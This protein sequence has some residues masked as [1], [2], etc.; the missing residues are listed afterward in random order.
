MGPQAVAAGPWTERRRRAAELRDR[1]PFAGEVLA[2]YDALLEA[3]ARV[4]EAARAE[5]DPAQVAAY[6]AARALPLVREVTRSRGPEKLARAVADG[7]PAAGG[8]DAVRRWLEGG[9]L[10]PVERY[11]ARASAGPVLEALGEAAGAACAGPRDARHCPRCGGPPQLSV[12]AASGEDLV[13]PRRYLECARCAWR[14]PY[15]RMTCAGCGEMDTGRLPIFAEEGAMLGEATGAVVRGAR[16][17]PAAQPAAHAP[18]FPH[19]GI[20]GCR[21][22]GRY[23]LNVDLGRDPRAVPVVDEM[24]AIPLALYASEQGLVKIVPN[25]MGL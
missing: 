25:L 8:E 20:H 24:A 3:Q 4:Y 13:T 17:L 9:E 18:R 16:D 19:L 23:L 15:A 1:W 6:A 10:S 11:L 14:W 7:A 22:C 12:F 5:A 2:F 21:A